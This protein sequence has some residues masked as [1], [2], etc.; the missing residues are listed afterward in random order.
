[1]RDVK[2]L[3][4]RARK[5]EIKQFTG[6]DDVY[7]VPSMPDLIIDTEN[8]TP[9]CVIDCILKSLT[10]PNYLASLGNSRT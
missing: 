8:T 9:E 10:D 4:K 2:G 5:G 6:I 3:Y 7:E 1:M